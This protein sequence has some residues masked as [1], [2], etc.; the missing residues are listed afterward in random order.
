MVTAVGGVEELVPT[1]DFGAVLPDG[2]PETV[3]R[4]VEALADDP[5]G[6]RRRGSAL[7]A[8]VEDAFSWER[9]AEAVERACAAAR[10]R[11]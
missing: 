11:S 2:A 9:T 5:E 1:A 7:R 10:A 8:L 4:A 6:A 3:A